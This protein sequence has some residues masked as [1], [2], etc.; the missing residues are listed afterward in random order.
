MQYFAEGKAPRKD[1]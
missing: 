1:E